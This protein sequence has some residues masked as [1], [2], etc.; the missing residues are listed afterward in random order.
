MR[1][2]IVGSGISGLVVA[3]LLQREH[4][5]T[6]Y[7]AGSYAGGHA[8]TVRVDT[9]NETH[10]VDTG[11]IVFNDR[12]Y[13]ELRTASRAARCGRPAVDDDLRR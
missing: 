8:N 4:D 10:A 7:E 13:P 9:P 1:I 5:L 6:V 2:A 12:N 3:H 11:F